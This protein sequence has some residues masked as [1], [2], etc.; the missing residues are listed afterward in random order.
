[1][2]GLFVGRLLAAGF[3]GP[4]C[5]RRIWDWLGLSGLLGRLDMMMTTI[6]V[7][8]IIAHM[9]RSCCLLAIWSSSSWFTVPC[10][11]ELMLLIKTKHFR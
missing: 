8:I 5:D 4:A 1:V 2:N 11:C 9:L 7:F 6:G 10:S 3:L